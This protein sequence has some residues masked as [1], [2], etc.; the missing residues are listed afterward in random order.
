MILLGKN[1][2]WKISPPK[3]I[4]QFL[5]II[6]QLIPENSILYIEGGGL[7]PKEIRSYLEDKNIKDRIKIVGGT[8]VPRPHIYRIP[9]TI[10]N[11]N[12]LA[13]LF[14]MYPFPFGSIHLHIYKNNKILMMSYDAFLDSF[15]I[16]SEIPEK[17]IKKFCDE[18]NL[19]YDK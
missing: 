2:S 7:P 8:L 11:L 4:S 6:G 13:S 1:N 9:A 19:S 5:R 12:E 10:T 14:E 15:L 17:K 3:N 18:L 16:S